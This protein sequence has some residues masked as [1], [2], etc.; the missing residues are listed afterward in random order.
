MFCADNRFSNQYEDVKFYKVDVDEVPDVAQELG[1]RA[2]PTF[3]LFKNGERVEEIV[4]ANPK[5]LEAAIVKH[6]G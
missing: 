6:R 4:G 1:V 5:A 3:V 2:M